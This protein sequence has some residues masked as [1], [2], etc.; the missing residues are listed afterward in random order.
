MSK[1]FEY[2][3]IFSVQTLHRHMHDDLKLIPTAV[4]ILY[5]ILVYRLTVLS[6][7]IY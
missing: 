6:A 2:E 5:F 3:F 4:L 7:H 1:Q